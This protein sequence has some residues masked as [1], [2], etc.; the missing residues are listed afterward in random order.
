VLGQ[1]AHAINVLS[2]G[3]GSVSLPLASPGGR[4]GLLEAPRARSS[5]LGDLTKLA[6]AILDDPPDAATFIAH[7]ITGGKPSSDSTIIS[8]A[9]RMSPLVSPTPTNVEYEYWLPVGWTVDDFLSLSKTGIDAVVQTDI[10]RIDK[11]A[12]SWIASEAPN[13]AIRADGAK[14]DPWAPEIGYAKFSEAE[15]AWQELFPAVVAVATSYSS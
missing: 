15:A 14:F 9:V 13:Q 11:Y 10:E 3:S 7:V 6:G 5:T 1:D 4:C 12:A 2:L 8:R